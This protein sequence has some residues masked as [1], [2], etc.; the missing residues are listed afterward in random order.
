MNLQRNTCLRIPT[1]YFSSIMKIHS[2]TTDGTLKPENLIPQP[3]HQDW[4][5]MSGSERQRF[6]DQCDCQ[7]HN[8]TQL[9]LPEIQNLKEACG[10]KLCGAFEK[11]TK[12]QRG[13]ALKKPL[14]IGTSIAT[15]A[16]ASCSQPVE[17][18]H[19]VGLICV[20][21]DSNK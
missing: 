1:C 4:Q 14:I 10:G 12:I 6:C 11:D 7:V 13:N 20:P 17:E 9:S 19:V 15:L 5:K 21:E 8:L 16:L 2:T 18:I 3:C